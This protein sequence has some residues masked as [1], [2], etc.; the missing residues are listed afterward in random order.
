[1]VALFPALHRRAFGLQHFGNLR[2]GKPL[3]VQQSRLAS[4]VI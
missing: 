2:H 3:P 1:M 4:R